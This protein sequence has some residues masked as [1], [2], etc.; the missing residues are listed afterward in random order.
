MITFCLIARIIFNELTPDSIPYTNGIIKSIRGINP[1]LEY[2]D[3][4]K[5]YPG[6]FRLNRNGIFNCTLPNV[7]IFNSFIIKL[8]DKGFFEEF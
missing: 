8:I 2:I 1:D 5:R 4:N 3:N 6:N 7:D